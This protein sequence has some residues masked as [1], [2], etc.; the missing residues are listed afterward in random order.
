MPSVA[1]VP[2]T[3]SIEVVS[4]QQPDILG[5][6]AVTV[7]FSVEI[8]GHDLGVFTQCDGLS[9]EVVVEQREEGGQN[10][11]VHQLPGRMKF[12]N[13]K[14]TRPLN[15]D[16]AKVAA[17]LASMNGVITRTTGEIK[18]RTANGD[19]IAAWTLAG[20]IPVKWTGPQFNVEGPKV[21]TETLEIAHH[22]FMA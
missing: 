8:T 4:R 22:G 3:N 7:C 12:T 9:C 11:F 2:K 6:P 18:A 10:A 19:V 14:L 21:A 5:D 17:W 13:V 1:A 20:V 16:S 15:A